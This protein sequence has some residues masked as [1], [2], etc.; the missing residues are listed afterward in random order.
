MWP[1]LLKFMIGITPCF[2]LEIQF[3]RN[4]SNDQILEMYLN[5]IPYGGTAYG[6][7]AAANLYFGKH[8]NELSLL[9]AALL[10]GLP[11]RPSVYSPYGTQPELAK[12]RQKEV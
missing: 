10:A 6:I 8:T 2:I 1:L 3:E 5:A 11:Q 4:L 7:E 9:E 12:V